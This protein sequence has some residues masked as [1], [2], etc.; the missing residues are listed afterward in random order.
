MLSAIQTQRRATADIADS[1]SAP[2]QA[3]AFPSEPTCPILV[4]DAGILSHLGGRCWYPFPSWWTM[5]VSSQAP[6][7]ESWL[8]VRTPSL[9][10][11]LRLTVRLSTSF[12]FAAFCSQH[13]PLGLVLFPGIPTYTPARM[14]MGLADTPGTSRL[15]PPT[16]CPCLP[17]VSDAPRESRLTSPV[18]CL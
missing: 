12:L 11:A 13:H 9:P 16:S 1:Q 3:N 7:P 17:E 5:L 10:P 18:L 15:Q 4:N 8:R 6:T 14:G 2:L